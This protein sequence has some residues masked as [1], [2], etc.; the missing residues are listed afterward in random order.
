MST[1]KQ[2]DTMTPSRCWCCGMVITNA[3]SAPTIDPSVRLCWLCDGR[4]ER[5]P[6][7]AFNGFGRQLSLLNAALANERETATI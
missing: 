6:V 3:N 2:E 4:I 7:S 5:R 1:S